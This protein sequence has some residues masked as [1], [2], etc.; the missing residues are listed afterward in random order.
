MVYGR[1]ASLAQYDRARDLW[2]KFAFADPP[3]CQDQDLKDADVQ[4]YHLILFGSAEENDVV[5]RISG[6]LPVRWA[7][8][9]A[10]VGDQTYEGSDLGFSLVYPN[11]LYPDKLVVWQGGSTWGMALEA[12]HILDFLPDY[13]IFEPECLPDNSPK[14]LCAGFFDSEWRLDPRLMRRPDVQ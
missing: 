13:V 2:R 5:K 11:P 8:G 12:N 1:G 3:A 7:D 4:R 10:T 9:I 14:V 6:S